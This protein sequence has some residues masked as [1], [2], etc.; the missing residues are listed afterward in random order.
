MHRIKINITGFLIF[1]R[2]LLREI[3]YIKIVSNVIKQSHNWTNNLLLLFYL[4]N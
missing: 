2:S 3:H 1:F 4:I